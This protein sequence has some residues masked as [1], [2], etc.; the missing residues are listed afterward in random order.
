MKK[1]VMG[2]LALMIGA[3]GAWAGYQ[4]AAAPVEENAERQSTSGEGSGMVE[5]AQWQGGVRLADGS[6]MVLI[7]KGGLFQSIELAPKIHC[8]MWFSGAGLAPGREV[9]LSTM[10]GG[11]INGQVIDRV[12]VGEDGYLRFEYDNGVRGVQPI[13]ATIFGQMATL[14]SVKVAEGIESAQEEGAEP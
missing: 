4:S 3:G 13:Q 12:V 2:L 10:N 11:R 9:L 5:R 6:E 7:N 1:V 14:V 8:S